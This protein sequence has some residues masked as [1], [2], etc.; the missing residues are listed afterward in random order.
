MWKCSTIISCRTFPHVAMGTVQLFPFMFLRALGQRLAG[1]G[2]S[3]S[4]SWSSAWGDVLPSQAIVVRCGSRT[5]IKSAI[6]MGRRI[7]GQ[8]DDA[9]ELRDES[10]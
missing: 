3:H 7:S 5:N 1:I 6:P 4:S 2:A 8:H 9:L 10:P